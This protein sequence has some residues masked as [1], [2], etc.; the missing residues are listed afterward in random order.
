[1]K[2]GL[3]DLTSYLNLPNRQI[4]EGISLSDF[5]DGL[6]T[7]ATHAC[8]ETA[9]EFEDDEFIQVGSAFDLWNVVI[10][11]DL[12]GIGWMDAVPFARSGQK[13]IEKLRS[14]GR[15]GLFVYISLPFAL[16][17]R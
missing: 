6:W 14:R 1:M 2:K 4:E 8:A 17:L 11:H 7:D 10:G 13:R 3:Q 9:V 16:S 12:L 15:A 5:D